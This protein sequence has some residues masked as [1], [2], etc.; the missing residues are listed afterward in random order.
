MTKDRY[1]LMTIDV[2]TT[3]ILNRKLWDKTDEYVL[4]QGTPRLLD[5]Y[6]RYGIRTTFYTE[7]I[8]WLYPNVIRMVHGKRHEIGSHYEDLSFYNDNNN[9]TIISS[10]INW[11]YSKQYYPVKTVSIHYSYSSR[12]N[13]SLPFQKMILLIYGGGINH[14]FICISIRYYIIYMGCAWDK[15]KYAINL[16]IKSFAA[17]E[18][19]K[20]WMIGHTLFRTTISGCIQYTLE[21]IKNNTIHISR[22]NKIEY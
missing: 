10:I 6:E 15:D 16:I 19:L 14:I 5:L 3:S 17:E 1:Y 9:K 7:Y 8:A 12:Y 22:N 21:R 11:K 20:Q 4:Q 2:E 13:N 18:Y